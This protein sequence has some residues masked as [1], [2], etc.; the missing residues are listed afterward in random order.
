[1]AS[2]ENGN[3]GQTETASS[4]PT[5]F[6]SE[7]QGLGRTSGRAVSLGL[8]PNPEYGTEPLEVLNHQ[9][10]TTLGRYPLS[11]LVEGQTVNMVAPV[12]VHSAAPLGV[13]RIRLVWTELDGVWHKVRA[14]LGLW[15]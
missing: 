8:E 3:F 14:Q 15:A 10:Q 1:M 5:S 6:E 13:T 4:L 2:A 11:N 7:K 12:P 9:T